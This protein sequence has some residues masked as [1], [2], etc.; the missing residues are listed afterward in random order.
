MSQENAYPSGILD[1]SL[2][3][4]DGDGGQNFR[5]P[6]V[7]W[8]PEWASRTHIHPAFWIAAFAEMTV[9]EAKTSVVPAQAGPY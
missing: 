9:A 7:G 8:D 1:S 5:R 2:R 4:N 3:W 6:S